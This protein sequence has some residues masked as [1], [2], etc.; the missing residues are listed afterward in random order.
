MTTLERLS[1]VESKQ[2]RANSDI[3]EIKE[4]QERNH[5]DLASRFDVLSQ[6]IHAKISDHETRLKSAEEV[7]EPFAKFKRKLWG[8]VVTSL[9]TIATIAIILLETQRIK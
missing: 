3:S 1:V 8:A 4:N 2:D 9:L 5:A 7:L 6:T